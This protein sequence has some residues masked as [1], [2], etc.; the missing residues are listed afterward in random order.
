MTD[1]RLEIDGAIAT[2][3]LDGP[4]T[5]NALD[6]RALGELRAAVDR[7][8]AAAGTLDT[9]GRVRVLVLRGEGSVFC[10]GRDI[11]AVDVDRDD[12]HA[13]LTEH[14]G[15]VFES[16]RA[17]PIPVIAQVQGAALGLGFGLAAAADLVYAAADAKFGSP[18]AALG[19][20]LDSGAHR[21]FLDAFGYHRTMDLILTGELLTGTDAAAAGLVSR[22]LPAAQLAERV[23]ATAAR[24]AA[25][26]ARAS[27]MEK[28]YTQEAFDQRP[29]V[30]QVLAAEARLQEAARTTADY[31][32]GFTAFQGRRRPEFT[33]R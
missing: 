2:I 3:V 20:V 15:P 27:A 25:G 31:R 26:P 13:F 14:F 21:Y 10:A 16:L 32:E 29:P 33:G 11:A 23:T 7:V 28:A 30:A 12:A 24:L 5:R 17:L 1:I 8:T 6:A 9:A 19:A 18:F 4:R 22:A